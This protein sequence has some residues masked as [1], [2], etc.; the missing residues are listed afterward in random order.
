MKKISK[1]IKK[2]TVTFALLALI[3]GSFGLTSV[4]H[5]N[6]VAPNWNATGSYVIDMQYNGTSNP[7]DMSL[8]QD[9]SGNLTGSGGSPAGA[10]VYTWTI[11]SGSVS[12]D[13]INI[14]ANYTATADAVTP[15]TV[16]NLIG[17]IAGDGTISGTWSDNYQ[18]GARAGTFSTT[19]GKALSLSASLAA[20]DFGV[21]N[22]SNVKG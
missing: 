22:V 21:M 9:S 17:T 5:A 1:L 7:H 8:V 12:G 19:T 4:A 16:L 6:T 15:Q 10:N 20:Q 11:T 18:G 13:A 3:A 2:S 14:T